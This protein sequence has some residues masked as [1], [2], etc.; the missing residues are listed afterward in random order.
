MHLSEQDLSKACCEAMLALLIMHELISIIS[1]V[2]MNQLNSKFS[3]NGFKNELIVNFKVFIEILRVMS[4][5]S[6]VKI[7]FS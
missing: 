3:C 5:H 1:K 6:K 7:L 2:G 4:N